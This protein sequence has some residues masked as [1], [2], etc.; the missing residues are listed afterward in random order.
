L[1]KDDREPY[2]RQIRHP[3]DD[4]RL[5]FEFQSQ[6]VIEIESLTAELVPKP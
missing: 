4:F 2:M 6:R 5:A 1:N 3:N